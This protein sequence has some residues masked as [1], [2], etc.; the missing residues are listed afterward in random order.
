MS[1]GMKIKRKEDM[2]QFTQLKT[3]YKL[4]QE[5]FK[6]GF[7]QLKME[8]QDH[9]KKETGMIS[10][11]DGFLTKQNADFSLY[12][13]LSETLEQLERC[14]KEKPSRELSL[15]KT[16]IQEAIFWIDQV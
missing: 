7:E 16:K 12:Y 2:T 8:V 11:S 9:Q 13:C 3:H 15:A 10:L 14:I 1:V 6:N 5:N 4:S